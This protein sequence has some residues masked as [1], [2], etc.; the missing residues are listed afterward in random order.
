MLKT[1]DARGKF[2]EVGKVIF[3]HKKGAIYLYYSAS[4]QPAAIL[5]VS[6]SSYI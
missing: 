4:F 2:V 3:A 6:I 1:L 5:L